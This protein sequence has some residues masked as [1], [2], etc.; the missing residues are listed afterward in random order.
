MSVSRN[1]CWTN[2]A[3]PSMGVAAQDTDPSLTRSHNV[4]TV[5]TMKTTLIPIGNSR[6]IRIPKPLIEQCGLTG[7]I[8]MDVRDSTILI[9][10]ARH[11]R[12]GWGKAF[13]QMAQ[14][15]DD[16]L[17]DAEPVP[18]RWDEEEWEWK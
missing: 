18:T 10:S 16:K 2:A 3:G 9:Y 13:K 15:G 6:G 12:S 1:L 7:T 8:E 17:L 11:P 4:T 14:A 5:M